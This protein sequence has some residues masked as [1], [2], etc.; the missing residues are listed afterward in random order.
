MKNIR[1]YDGRQTTLEYRS[2]SS[3]QTT[4]WA[5]NCTLIYYC[6]EIRRHVLS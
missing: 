5:F 4:I 6:D 2:I 1:D 3:W